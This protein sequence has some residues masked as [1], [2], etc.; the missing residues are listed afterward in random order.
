MI[1]LLIFALFLISFALIPNLKVDSVSKSLNGL[2]EH[3]TINVVLLFPPILS[4]KTLVS[5]LFLYGICVDLLSVK[6][7]ITFPKQLRL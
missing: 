6:A 5:L 7:L 2:G 4:Y 1:S 3:V